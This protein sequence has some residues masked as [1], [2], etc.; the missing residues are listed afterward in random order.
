MYDPYSDVVVPYTGDIIV[1][2][3][4]L[5]T[6]LFFRGVVT[7]F[8]SKASASKP[9]TLPRGTTLASPRQHPHVLAG[10]K[11]CSELPALP[12]LHCE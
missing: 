11:W 4:V 7:E 5:Q 8:S 6:N 3:Q 10:Y 9:I 2:M 12:K 1:H